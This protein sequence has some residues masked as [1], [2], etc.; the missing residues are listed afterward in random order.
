M[1]NILP[2]SAA[3]AVLLTVAAADFAVPHDNRL[4]TS[5]KQLAFHTSHL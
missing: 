2:V 4:Q 1:Q 3:L 5:S